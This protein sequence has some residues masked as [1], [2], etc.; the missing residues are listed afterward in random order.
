MRDDEPI[1]IH[2]GQ[3]IHASNQNSDRGKMLLEAFLA[4]QFLVKMTPPGMYLFNIIE[5][6][7]HKTVTLKSVDGAKRQIQYQQSSNG[8]TQWQSSYA[9]GGDSFDWRQYQTFIIWLVVTSLA[10]IILLSIPTK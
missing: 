6:G 4:N 10:T 3:N 8:G 2:V 5:K 9:E 7:K 1:L